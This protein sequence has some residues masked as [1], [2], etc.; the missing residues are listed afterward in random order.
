[1]AL[2]VQYFQARCLRQVVNGA[3]HICKKC[4]VLAGGKQS[5]VA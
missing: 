2:L 4:F 5:D 1:M 3:G